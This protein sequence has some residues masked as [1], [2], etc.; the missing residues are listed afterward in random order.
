MHP[1]RAQ[2]ERSVRAEGGRDVTAVM[3][4]SM[5]LGPR[6]EAPREA[7][8]RTRRTATRAASA[9]KVPARCLPGDPARGHV[10]PPGLGKQGRL[11]H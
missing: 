7:L 5:P 4:P 11:R 1:S 6:A 10:P 2:A 3:D 9:A 8:H